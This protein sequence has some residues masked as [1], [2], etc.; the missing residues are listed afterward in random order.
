MSVCK[1]L[2]L[3]IYIYIYVCVC[4]CMHAHRVWIQCTS[5]LWTA[6]CFHMMGLC[7][8]EVGWHVTIFA[9][10]FLR[11]HG[12]NHNNEKCRKVNKYVVIYL[13]E[14]SNTIRIMKLWL[15]LIM[16][17]W[18]TKFCFPYIHMLEI[19]PVTTILFLKC[20]FIPVLEYGTLLYY[21]LGINRLA[22]A[23]L[24]FGRRHLAKVIRIIIL[25]EPHTTEGSDWVLI[26]T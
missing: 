20:R 5:W 26:F 8:V 6:S 12:D 17:C 24:S 2:L 22:I 9:E 1:F 18:L 4:E 25:V 11:E 13:C 14:W 23:S 3:Y 19:P 10:P 16:P 21:E 15:T 7:V